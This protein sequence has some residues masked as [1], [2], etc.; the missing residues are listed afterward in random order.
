MANE[1]KLRY[2]LKRVSTDLEAAHDRIREMEE[3]DTEPIAIIGMSCRYPGGVRSPEEL[4]DLVASGADGM[5]P[6][7]PDRGWNTDSVFQPAPGGTGYAGEG[8]FVRDAGDFDAAFFGISPREAL[9]TDPQQRLLL[10]TSWEAVERAGIDP[11]TLRGTPTGIFA[12]T[13]GQDY[14]YLLM[15]SAGLEGYTGTG[16]AAAVISGRVSYTLGLEGPAVTVDTACSSSLVALHLAAQALRRGECTLALAGGVTVMATPGMFSSFSA[17]GGLARDGRCKAFAAA[18]DGTG[19]AEGV[20]VLLVERLSDAR[21]NGHQVLAVLRGSAVNQD[22]ASNGL[23]APNGPSQQRVIEQ[24]LAD[25]S[26]TPSQVD[27]VEAHGTG[28][29][30]GD[31]IEAQALLATYGQDRPA[32][33]PLWLGSV[34]SNIGHTQAAAGVAGVIKMVMAM[35]RDALPATLH[36]DAPTPQV[37]WTTG[38]VR[39]LTDAVPWPETG[40]PRRAGVSSFGISGTNAHVIIEQAATPAATPADTPAATPAGTGA[41]E[42]P[43]ALP[44]SARGGTALAA[45]AARLRALLATRP[46]YDLADVAHALA[47]TRTAFEDRAVVVAEDRDDV[48]LQLEALANGTAGPVRGT[49]TEG[50]VAFLFSGQGS[51]RLGTGRELA[52]RFPVFRDALDEVCAH[53]DRHLQHPLRSVLFAEEGSERAALLHRTAYTQAALFAVEVALFRLLA[54]W[55]VRPGLLAGHSI[56]EVS[57]VHVAGVLSLD[58][59]CT[60][61]AARGRLMQ[62]LP[63]GGAMVAVEA[64]EDEVVQALASRTDRAS[65]AAVNGPRSVV[66]SGDEDEVLT[67]AAHF[68]ARNRKTKRLKVSHAFHSPHMDPMLDEFGRVLRALTFAPPAIPVVSNVTGRILTAEEAGSADYWVRHVRRTVRFDDC[69]RTLAGQGVKTYVELGPDGVLS[70]MVADCLDADAG[71]DAFPVLRAGRPETRSAMTALSRSYVRGVDCDWT[72]LFPG[73]GQVTLPT[74]AFQRTRYWPESLVWTAAADARGGEDPAEAGFWSAVERQDLDAVTGTLALDGDQPLSTVLPALADW[75]RGRRDQSAIDSWRY[76]VQWRPAPEPDPAVPAGT[77]L[78]AGPEDATDD[79]ADALGAHGVRVVRVPSPHDGALLRDAMKDGGITG[80]LALTALHGEGTQG[81]QDTLALVQALADARLRAPLWLAT[82]GAVAINGSDPL[83]APEQAMVWGLGQVVAVEEPGLWGGLID[84]PGT[85]DTRAARRLCAVL[86]D[87]RR[88]EDQLAIRSSGVHV[89]RLVRSA[90]QLPEARTPWQPDGTVLVTGGTGALGTVAARWLARNGAAHLLLTSRS[91]P[92]AP[93]ARD[94]QAELTQLGARVTVAACD[95]TDRDALAALLA[96]VPAAHPLTAVVHTAGVLDDGMLGS[97][98]P[99]RVERV[100]RPKADA[101]LHLHELTR[102]LDLSAFVL[103][104]SLAATF[105]NAGQAAYAA[106]NAFLDAIAAVRHAQALPATSIGWGAWDGAG[107]AA[108]PLVAERVRRG[109]MPPLPP[110]PAMRALRQAVEGGAPHTVVADVDWERFAPSLPP[111]RSAFIGEIPDVQRLSAATGAPAPEKAAESALHEQ[112]AGTSPQE[113][114]RILLALVC[115]QAAAVLGHASADGVQP[116][117]AF[118]ELGFDSLTAVELRN[119]LGAS[120]GLALPATLVFDYPTPLVLSRYLR[121]E[122]AGSRTGPAQDAP[123]AVLDD[124]PIAIVGMSCRFPGGVQSPEQFWDL[125]ESGTDAVSPLPGDRGWDIE[126]LY[127]ADP[128]QRGTSY[129]REGGFLHDVA[130]FDAGFF[131]IAPREALAMDPQQRLLLETS[132]EAF[133]RAGIDPDSVRGGRVGVFAGTNSQDYTGL[134][135]GSAESA[136][137]FVATGNA[138]S[139][140][141]GRVSY[142]LGLEGPAVTV[143][144]A[145]S[146]SLVALHLAVQ[147]L[148]A[149]ECTLAL[150]GGV[151]VMSTPSAFIEFSRQRGLSSDGRCKAFAESADGTGWGEGVGVLLV[152]R[153]SDARRNGREVLAVVRGSAVNQDGASNGLTA[154]NGPSQQR[155]IRQALDGAGLTA[156]QV[157]AVEAHGTGTTL[158]D[159]IEAQA[160]LATYGQD[161]PAD[162]PLWLGSV[163]SNI[164]HTQAAAGVAGVIKMV[165]A[166]RHGVLPPTLHVD[167]PSSHVDWS[168][169]AVELLTAPV[170]W[171]ETDRPR[172]A[173]VSSFGVSGTNAHTIIEQAPA[174]VPAPA[175]PQPD[176]PL[177]TGA[178]TAWVLSGRTRQALRD[179]ASRLLDAVGTA[180]PAALAHALATTRSRFEHRAALVAS[181]P[182]EFEAA[183]RVLAADGSAAGIVRGSAAR[184]TGPV[185][186]FP[187]QGAQW[188][189]MAKELLDTSGVFAARLAD[190]AQALAPHT[191]WSLEDVVREVPGAPGLDRV[192][193]VQPVLWAVMVSLAELWRACGVRPAAVIGHSQGEIAAAT[194]AGALSVED[195][196]RVVALRSRALLALSGKGGM[197]SVGEPAPL[198]RERLTAW[199][200][201][202]SVAAVNGPSSAVVAGEPEALDELLSTCEAGGVRGRRIAVDYASHSAQVEAIREELDR[203]LTGITPRSSTVPFY[204]T[205]TGATIDTAELDAGYWFRN[206]RSTVEF[207]A[208]TRA[209]L[210][211]GHRTFLEVGPHPVMGIGLQETFDAVKTEATAL[212]TLRRHEGG[213]HRFLTSLAE[214]H[215]AGV[216]PDW[217]AVFG[218]RTGHA[219]LPTYA[220]QRSRYWPKPA[221]L[222]APA[223]HRDPVDDAFWAAVE[224]EDPTALAGMLGA[225]DDEARR[226]WESVLP[227]LTSWRRERREQSVLDSWRYGITWVPVTPAT[228]TAT[229]PSGT[230]LIVSPHG[231]ASRAGEAVER[232][233]ARNGARTIHVLF[234]SDDTGRAMALQRLGAAVPDGGPIEG[235]LSFLA[236]DDRPDPFHPVV[237]AGV[238]ATTSLIQAMTD[239]DLVAPLWCLTRGAVS[240]DGS[241]PL[242]GPAQAQVWGLGRVIGLEHPERWG[243][244]IDLSAEPDERSVAQVCRLLAGAGDEDQLAVR[245]QG[246]FARRLGR[247]PAGPRPAAPSRWRP[248]G[249]ALITGGMGAL[250][251]HVA[252][253]LAGKG[254]EHLVLTGRRGADTPGALAL[255]DELTALGAR[256]T[257]A[258]CDVADPTTLTALV[259]DLAQDEKAPVRTVVHAAG[260]TLVCGLEESD[261]AEFA[262]VMSAKAAGATHLDELFDDD[263]LDAFVLFASGAG[264]WGGS[265]QGA[266]AVSNCHLDALAERRRARGLAATS[267]A[268][269]GWAGGGMV[270]TAAESTLT[271]LGLRPMDPESA[272][273]ALVQAVEREETCLTVADIDWTRFA[274]AFTMAR[275]RPLIED[276]PEAAAVLQPSEDDHDAPEAAATALADRLAGASEAERKR[277]LLDLVRTEAAAVLGHP[278][279]DAV[280]PQRAFREMGFD[281][282]MAV[283]LRNRLNAATGLRL[284]TTLVFDEPSPTGLR[285]RLL[286]ELPPPGTESSDEDDDAQ[287]RSLLATIPMARIRE[288]GLLDALLRPEEAKAPQEERTPESDDRVDEINAMDITA[289]VRMATRTKEA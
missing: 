273:Q 2:F 247:S 147:A 254:A 107:M 23:T 179:Q 32:N 225:G 78:V 118:R 249:T 185:L 63:E 57:A 267:V 214:A 35:Q 29:V 64:S 104:S 37:D 277:V 27:V 69:V 71:A 43:V 264:V 207:E 44:V 119:L 52:E 176:V 282:V 223:E 10:E 192:D 94:L 170:D 137:G 65:V 167:E 113:S 160:L 237:P 284:E 83:T 18:A 161:R 81:L 255:K 105:G 202:L 58:D 101:V 72:A 31:P 199:G 244:L 11:E 112:L 245:P 257:L 51:Q 128:D 236:E 221:A 115:G 263:S 3:R 77:W 126:R 186:V 152:E 211:D 148:R 261:P 143:D 93:G 14:P 86:A 289:L 213:P 271:R 227:S 73:A 7:P 262:R 166:M 84:L 1:E 222:P 243:G 256:V 216:S 70:A 169:G 286:R 125:L 30:L 278:G 150:A 239:L 274:P 122:L 265:A 171:P 109:G 130:D 55:G 16:S 80:V 203:L 82:R 177:D 6:F 79:I 97:L 238:A 232:E 193:V 175:A 200:D 33:R 162:R 268:W 224:S 135:M 76:E 24:A 133:E 149:G 275:P 36:V 250:G 42:G 98:T 158:G 88:T 174:D 258:A 49:V 182:A 234:E 201:R 146:S 41:Q 138:A 15:G 153:L 26:L 218:P 266:Y 108:D 241:G 248:R 280:D 62:A 19:F 235:V 154:P 144:T 276:I 5:T 103:F 190:C 21:R 68:E 240:V 215:V 151:T 184:D 285:D 87:T 164:G 8:G 116:G 54:H 163:K 196:A 92:D 131:G 159:P 246:V 204:S 67:V 220:F 183:L 124:D 12:G 48:L 129:V 120:T 194:V 99:E 102:H 242:A 110:E 281:S 187:G 89:R 53:L 25:A 210:A 283:E 259:K 39:L 4:W 252:R 157:D 66:V 178:T 111:G 231:V 136:E 61:V 180:D 205:L 219:E 38:E 198:L 208:A 189:G 95:V 123:V 132:W 270:D 96:S 75:R 22:G 45:Q 47:T 260:E 91:G 40:Q 9:A 191:D 229:A 114:E 195:A 90:P 168:A 117:R 188:P 206:L 212:G 209:A 142:A 34:K 288:S 17:Q 74:Y 85:L 141:S 13:N 172:R 100:L 20:G 121:D 269:G 197:V 272:V 155:V 59:A 251:S 165:M 50:R 173:G 28:T 228:A 106:G 233:L 56:G 217:R 60:L 139:V 145:C 134:L 253:W 127:S 230:W 279:A 287:V 226:S 181:K 156:D 140:V 46:E